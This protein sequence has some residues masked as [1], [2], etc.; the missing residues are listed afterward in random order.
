MPLPTVTLLVSKPVTASE[1]VKVNVVAPV[2]V[3]ATLSEMV[4]VG[5]VVSTTM[6]KEPAMLL[7]PEGTVV[8]V[9][10]LPKPASLGVALPVPVVKLETVRSVEV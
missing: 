2:A 10:A 6:A 5:A 4:T 1:K 8:E 3:P 9:R 7:T